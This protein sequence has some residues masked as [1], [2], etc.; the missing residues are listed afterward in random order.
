[1]LEATTT[2]QRRRQRPTRIHAQTTRMHLLEVAERLFAEHG[3]E[4]ASLRA[5][6]LAAGQSNSVAAQY[7]FENKIG[8]IEAIFQMRTPEVEKRRAALLDKMKGKDALPDIR[9][10]VEVLFLP[11]TQ[12]VELDGRNIYARF[13]QHFLSDSHLLAIRSHPLGRQRLGLPSD[14]N[15][16]TYS[17]VEMM[18]RQL[19]NI[20]EIVVRDRIVIQLR[21]FL[22]A[23]LHWEAAQK[24]D[25]HPWP[26]EIMVTDQLD[27]IATV[28]SMPVSSAVKDHFSAIALL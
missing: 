25:K 17:A 5:I 7:H 15:S 9:T 26:F 18:V 3:I 10:L 23:L 22:G 11:L 28:I 14:G 8:L 21:S 1:M 4:G 6:S 24:F 2:V 16:A 27:G 19:P 13:L 12:M 20:P